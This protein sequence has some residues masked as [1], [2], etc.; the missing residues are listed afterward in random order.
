MCRLSRNLGASTSWNP[1]GL[2]RPVMGL[3]YLFFYLS[4]KQTEKKKKAIRYFL[5]LLIPLFI[6]FN[7]QQ[8]NKCQMEHL[9][10]TRE[11]KI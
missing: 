4:L 1:V 7:Y 10:N 11:I 3:L 5:M 9:N 2:S 6:R 8:K